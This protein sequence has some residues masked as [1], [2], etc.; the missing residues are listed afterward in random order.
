[1]T[2]TPSRASRTLFWDGDRGL[3]HFD[4]VHVEFRA[5][6]RVPSLSIEQ[7]DYAP[8][9]GQRMVIERHGDWRSLTP[10]EGAEI[11]ALLLRMALAARS[12][13]C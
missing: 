10:A 1:V 11:D 8:R 2:D 6:P 12:V 9:A 13:L 4:G 3:A 5:A 7:I